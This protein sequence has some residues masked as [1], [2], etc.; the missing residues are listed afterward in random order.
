[1]IL[2]LK[3]CQVGE[4]CPHFTLV[5][6]K[7][8]KKVALDCVKS[9]QHIIII[10]IIINIVNYMYEA[11]LIVVEKPPHQAGFLPRP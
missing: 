10:I 6:T 2:I 8:K 5:D 9:L 11:Y 4:S 7:K 3:S 1:M